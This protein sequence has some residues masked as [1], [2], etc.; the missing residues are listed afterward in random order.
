GIS[1]KD[2]S[3]MWEVERNS[4]AALTESLDSEGT[5]RDF[6][7]IPNTPLV[8]ASGSLLNVT[9][10]KVLID[11]TK[12]DLRR[13]RTYYILPDQ[14]LML[15]EIAGKGA[16]YLYAINPF[17]NKQL[18]GVQLREM[19][20]LAQN[21]S[22]DN[23][24]YSA[25]DLE[26]M[27]NAAGDLVYDNGK[28]LAL[29]DMKSGELK[30]NEKL[31]A[32]YIF[33]SADGTRMVVAENRGGLGGMMAMGAGAKKFSKKLHLIDTESGQSVWK[34]E[35]KLDGN[36]LYVS[37]YDD[38]FLVVHDEGMNIFSFT[39]PKGDGRWKKDYKEKGVV[40]VEQVDEGLM[41]YFKNKRM[42][43]DPVSGDDKWKKAE[44]LEK[45]PSGFLWGLAKF[46]PLTEKVGK[47]DVTFYGSY[48]KIGEGYRSP[49]YNYSWLLVEEDRII[50]AV[51]EPTEGTRIGKP[52]FIITAIE[53]GGDEVET[54]REV[55]AIK[56]GLA[57]FDK[58]DN[59]YFFYND[60]GYVLMNYSTGK[61]WSEQAEEYYPDPTATLRTLTAIAST[62][63]AMAYTGAQTNRM[64]TN[65]AATGDAAGSARSFNNRMNAMNT[66]GDAAYGFATDRKINGRVDEKFAFFFARDGKEGATL[67][68]V[69]KSTG[70]E[71][72]KFRFDD[73]TPLYEIDYVNGR[74]YYQ[75]KKKF[76][77][78]KLK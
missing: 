40:N 34:K 15:L 62:A 51:A 14:D 28:Y 41:V 50:T 30:W 47:H 25:D 1:P 70:K 73:L 71:V 18:W 22:E 38:G 54:D 23:P 2:G 12:N 32:G 26:P 44:K 37:P 77:I 56:K 39:D 35:K 5:T 58:T 59:G 27:F 16:I 53:L 13:L 29:I 31:N 3:I 52:R 7:E 21:L 9:N 72:N 55:I 49:R 6:N 42:L 64:V 24:E 78:F 4:G 66:A 11:G 8:M 74:L 57:A 67:F 61:G 36:V 33:T 69:E 45:E 48:L 17:E 20:G 68:K 19:S 43:V 60:R 76:S 63:G 65:T 46:E 10:G 75:A